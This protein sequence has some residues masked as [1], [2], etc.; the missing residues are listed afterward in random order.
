VTIWKWQLPPILSTIH[1][2]TGAALAMLFSASGIVFGFGG[3]V[4][5]FTVPEAVR[6][7]QVLFF[8]SSS[9]LLDY[10]RISR[11]VEM[12]LCFQFHKFFSALNC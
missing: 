6:W 5:D 10:L 8:F 12:I 7:V 4:F 11:Q 9:L 2:G 3:A 1:R